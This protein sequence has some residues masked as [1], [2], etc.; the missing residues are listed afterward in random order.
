MKVNAADFANLS[1]LKLTVELERRLHGAEVVSSEEVP[2]DV[3]TMQ[4]RV[5]LTD[6]ATARRRTVSVVYPMEA[7]TAADRISVL[8]PLGTALFGAAVGDTIACDQPDG[9]CRLRVEEILYQP[10]QSMRA[11]LITGDP[12]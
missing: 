2:P 10:E 4:C 3:V 12:D 9:P 1:L 6:A 8:D 11:N 7:D 5:L